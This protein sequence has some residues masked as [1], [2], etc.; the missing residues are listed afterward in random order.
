M[1]EPIEITTDQAR[2]AA[3]LRRRWPGG[4]VISH[5]R[6]WGVILEV[7]LAG[8]TVDVVALMRDGRVE[9]DV[10]LAA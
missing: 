9:R 2:S 4:R 7:R 6:A 3:R 5:E 1:P 8:R 10:P